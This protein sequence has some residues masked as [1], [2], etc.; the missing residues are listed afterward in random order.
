[1][2]DEPSVEKITSG[3]L[4]A[5]LSGHEIYAIDYDLLPGS[6][7]LTLFGLLQNPHFAVSHA[8]VMDE[9]VLE[10][11]GD[12]RAHSTSSWLGRVVEVREEIRALVVTIMKRQDLK[13]HGRLLLWQS[14]MPPA[15]A[16]RYVYDTLLHLRVDATQAVAYLLQKSQNRTY[17]ESALRQLTDVAFK[18]GE[19]SSMPHALRTELKWLIASH[20]DS[21]EECLS[22]FGPTDLQWLSVL[23]H[24]NTSPTTLTNV[25][26]SALYSQKEGAM[27]GGNIVA[28]LS[29][30]W[31]TSHTLQAFALE[32]PPALAPALTRYLVQH[33]ACPVEL[34]EG[35]AE[36]LEE[37]ALVRLASLSAQS[38][39]LESLASHTSRAVR[40]AVRLNPRAP[41]HARVLAA[42]GVLG[43]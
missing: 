12:P 39:L 17:N 5:S 18:Q 42:L 41:E 10:S 21:P 8:H 26:T 14:A 27:D 25:I 24:P 16:A 31:W 33:P 13:L 37:P 15:S 29:H 2:S 30:G 11:F 38:H 7:A 32:I 22:L 34:L 20:P 35:N 3:D 23:S 28:A 9:I 40:N 1:M 4:D 36:T 6:L 19:G 43:G